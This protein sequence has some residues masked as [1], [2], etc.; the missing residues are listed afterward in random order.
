MTTAKPKLP[1][2]PATVA[3]Y[4][5]LQ[6]NICGKKQM[7]IA[8]EAGFEMPN[9]VTMIKQG[10]T[11]LP[12]EKLGRFAK[13]IEVDAVYLYKLCMAEYLPETWV[14]IERVLSQPA[15]TLNEIEIIN[16]IRQANVIN[17]KLTT[18]DE[19]QCLIAFANS[20]NGDTTSDEIET[21]R[22]RK[23]KEAEEK[24][25]KRIAKAKIKH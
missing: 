13:A 11:K 3:E 10:K 12:F 20:L 4:I 21:L 15:L 8:R 18:D 17:P 19:Q 7:D 9:V 2:K 22:A 14:E 25:K 1:S 6:I 24:E 5:E 16:T 23:E